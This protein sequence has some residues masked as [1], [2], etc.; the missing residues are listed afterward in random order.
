MHSLKEVHGVLGIHV[1]IAPALIELTKWYVF[2]SKFVD[3]GLVLH[4]GQHEI[5]FELGSVY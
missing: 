3:N 2:V 4:F 1:T 5:A